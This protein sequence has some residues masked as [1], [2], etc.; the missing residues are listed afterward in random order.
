MGSAVG[1]QTP[2]IVKSDK[3]KDYHAYVVEKY[4]FVKLSQDVID[5]INQDL[6]VLHHIN[7]MRDK[8]ANVDKAIAFLYNLIHVKQ[9]TRH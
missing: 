3:I 2:T 7:D 5:A 4:S 6:I 1:R 9:V 8:K